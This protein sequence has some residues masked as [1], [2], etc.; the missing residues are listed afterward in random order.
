MG[1]NTTALRRSLSAL[2]ACRP[3]CFLHNTYFRTGSNRSDM[4]K[5]LSIRVAPRQT[6]DSP[7]SALVAHSSHL[8]KS[9][10]VNIARSYAQSIQLWITGGLQWLGYVVTRTLSLFLWAIVT[11]GAP[12]AKS[13]T[14][15]G[16]IMSTP[17]S[18]Q[19]PPVH[20]TLEHYW[21]LD[22]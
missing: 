4:A 20:K 17:C 8:G 7:C 2:E 15:T 19:F 11:P 12:M 5:F 21:L 9:L 6:A 16:R 10:S 18:E 3:A 14:E 1:G 22:F 13:D